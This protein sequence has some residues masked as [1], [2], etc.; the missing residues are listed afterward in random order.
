MARR[1]ASSASSSIST[2]S[3]AGG[4]WNG[5]S[6]HSSRMPTID[7]PFCLMWANEN[8]T[9][10]LGRLG[11]GGADLAGL[12][13]DERRAGADR[14]LRPP[15]RRSALHS[16][17]GRPLL[18]IYRP[19]PD[20]QHGRRRSRVGASAFRGAL[21]RGSALR[22]GA[23]F[24]RSRPAAVRHGRRDRVSAAQADD[25]RSRMKNNGPATP[26]PGVHGTGVST[27]TTSSRTRSPSRR[28]RYPLIKTVVPGWDNDARRQGARDASCTMRRPAQISRAWLARAGAHGPRD[29]RSSA[30]NRLH[31]RLERVGG[32][33]PI[34]S[35]TCISARPILNATARAVSGR[36]RQRGAG[37]AAA[38]RAR[39]IPRRRAA[40]AARSRPPP[41][42]CARGR[43]R[44]PAARRR[45]PSEPRYADGW[46]AS[47]HGPGRGGAGAR[48]VPPVP[49]TG[50]AR[51]YREHAQRGGKGL[52]A[53]WRGSASPPPCSCTNCRACSRKR[54]C[55]PARGEGAAGAARH[56]VFA[57]PYVR[58]ETVRRPGVVRYTAR[59]V[60]S[61]AG[62]LQ[63]G[64]VFGRSAAKAA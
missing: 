61:S 37:A 8:W 27:T 59:A 21:R 25:R 50:A 60:H 56:V 34:S 12:P 48:L 51:G 52:S 24:R 44:V 64:A 7:M 57:A 30:S 20:P 2:G 14:D 43:D 32:R 45:R 26:R 47:D 15:L 33:A 22:H 40:P 28:R 3:T 41:A 16:R 29:S 11:R 9:P 58:D 19:R 18:M 46:G 42:P 23:E 53:A 31:Q 39:R 13:R 10:A 35:P 49:R 62:Q 1:P 54:S 38:G 63:G 5:R 55:W 36:R 17:A 6:R 4:C